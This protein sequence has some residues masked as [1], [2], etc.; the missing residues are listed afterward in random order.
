MHQRD[1][2][3]DTPKPGGERGVDSILPQRVRE[4]E[5][6]ILKDILCVGDASGEAVRRVEHELPMLAKY[7]L[8]HD[9]RRL[10]SRRR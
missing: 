2:N 8:Q 7:A 4:A 5:K 10:V 1:A 9:L 3:G 6:D